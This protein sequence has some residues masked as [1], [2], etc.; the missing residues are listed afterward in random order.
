MKPLF[1]V[2]TRLRLLNIKPRISP[3]TGCIVIEDEIPVHKVVATKVRVLLKAVYALNQCLIYD[4]VS[5]IARVHWSR[6][7]T[8]KKDTFSK[9]FASYCYNLMLYWPAYMC[10]QL[11]PALCDHMDCSPPGSQGCG[12]SQA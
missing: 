2:A 6:Y 11:C 4:L 10:A 8:N 9:L 3:A 12:I 5:L 1:P 7:D